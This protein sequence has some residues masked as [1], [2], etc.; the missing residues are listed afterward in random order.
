MI[1]INPLDVSNLIAGVA[2][3]LLPTLIPALVRLLR[4]RK[5][6]DRIKYHGTFYLYH[7]SGKDVGAVREKVINFRLSWTGRIKATIPSDPITRLSYSGYL[8][9]SK[10]GTCYIHL[11]G[12]QHQEQIM[13]V[14]KNPVHPIF[15]LTSGVL[16]SVTLDAEPMAWQAILSREQLDLPSASQLLGPRH[17]LAA[18]A[19]PPLA[20]LPKS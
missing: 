16:S 9:S 5:S 3:G 1:T 7:W 6:V 20:M 15:R 14:I 13:I 17:L 12:S 8:Y 10:V 19:L 18:P 4:L 11:L 2:L